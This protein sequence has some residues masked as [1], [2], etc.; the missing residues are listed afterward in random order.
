M[1]TTVQRVDQILEGQQIIEMKDYAN[2][3][4]FTQRVLDT[5]TREIGGGIQ[6]VGRMEF[7]WRNRRL[8][9]IVDTVMADASV[10]ATSIQVAN[11]TAFHRDQQVYYAATEDMFYVDED[12]GGDTNTGYVKVRGKGG[13]GGIT[14]ALTAGDMLLIGPESHAEAEGIPPAFANVEEEENAFAFQ[15]DETIKLSDILMAEEVY[16]IPELQQQRK[17][18]FIEQMKRMNI[19]MYKSIGGRETVSASGARRHA[20]TGINEY[21]EG[22]T[23]DMSLIPGGLTLTTI[24][25]LV[26]P[27]TLWNETAEQKCIILGQN[28]QSGISALP[29]QALRAQSGSALKWG[30]K[31][32]MLSTAFGDLNLTYDPLLSEENGMA[33]EMYVLSTGNIEQVQ[34]RTLPAVFKSNIQNSTDIHNQIDAYTGTR[35]IRMGLLEQSR[36]IKNIG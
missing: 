18:K 4:D 36:R 19:A 16:G 32:K 9:T 28:A 24:G 3:L 31:V 30:S 8:A 17:D 35:G 7:K 12:T 11:P 1:S 25:E 6:N 34:L 21:L 26:R 27:T 22:F 15:F 20:M 33:G 14:T 13:S 5:I 29:A 23:D 10:G 2:R